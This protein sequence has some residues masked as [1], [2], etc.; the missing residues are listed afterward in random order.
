M[1][2]GDDPLHVF[3]LPDGRWRGQVTDGFLPS[4]G[5][6]RR[7]VHGA[8]KADARAAKKALLR[9]IAAGEATT[10][11]RLTVK[12]WSDEWLTIQEGRIRPRTLKDYTG[13]VH[14]WIV[15]TIG[16][17]RLTELTP[18]HLRAITAAMIGADV[19]TSRA[20]KVH[21]VAMKMLRDAVRDGHMVPAAV[22][23]MKGPPIAINDRTDIPLDQALAVL[24][25]AAGDPDGS[26]WAIAF[27][28]GFRQGER[29]GLTW[30][31]VDLDAGVVDVSWQ[32]QPLPFAHDCGDAPCGAKNAGFCPAR[33]LAAPSNYE[34][35]QLNGALCLV[36]PKTSHGWRVVPLVPWAVSA[37]EKWRA[38]AP[39]SPHGLVW[40]R[41][42]GHPVATADDSAEWRALQDRAGIRHV[43]G[44]RYFGHEIRH[45]T[46]T[47]L[48][49]LGVDESVRIA[50][51]GH[52]SITVTRGYQHVSV[53]QARAALGAAA[54]RLG[55]VQ[56]GK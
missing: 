21:V 13:I 29:L 12:K 18:T 42:D 1:A 10:T 52:S 24:R 16:K 25:V 3:Q 8:T 40:P 11:G 9:K 19:S 39:V 53:D 27:L 50:I 34:Y 47:L 26:K 36:R 51:L 38:V 49:S 23:A 14:K 5:P 30:Q 4:G 48:M 22:L 15:P 44:R 45:T 41:A 2:R 56:K 43:A 31:C 32:L 17:R 7:Y 37:L 33:K 46:A 20:S 55:L 35:R 28:Q 6:R 54:T